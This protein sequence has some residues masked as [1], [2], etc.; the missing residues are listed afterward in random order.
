MTILAVRRRAAS[1]VPATNEWSPKCVWARSDAVLAT[2]LFPLCFTAGYGWEASTY[3]PKGLP[4]RL[5]A[6]S[7]G[8][9]GIV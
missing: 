4:P 7:V 2:D 1:S 6:G 3:A 8:T 9:T 5:G